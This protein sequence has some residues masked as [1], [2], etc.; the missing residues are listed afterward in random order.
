MPFNKRVLSAATA[1]AVAGSLF[2]AGCDQQQQQGGGMPPMGPVEVGVVTITPQRVDLTSTLSGRVIPVRRAEIRPQVSGLITDVLFTQGAL[3]KP[4]DPLFQIDPAPYK[5]TADAATAAVARAEAGLEIARLNERRYAEL[6]RTSATSRQSYDD[7]VATRKQA[8]AEVASAKASLAAAQVDLGRTLIVSPIAGRIGLASVSQGAL[9]RF[10]Q[11]EALAI[12]HQMDPIYVDVNQS[13]AELLRLKAD[14]AR[15]ALSDVEP[16]SAKVRLI[17]EDGSAYDQEGEMKLAEG[18]V[19][20]STGTVTL[21]SLFPNPKEQLLPGMFVRATVQV[22][23][24]DKGLLVPQRGITRSPTGDGVAMVVN[25]KG[26]VE[27]RKVTADRAVGDAW[28]VTE[29]IAAGDKVIID[30]LQR[31]QPGMPV[32]P[33][34]GATAA[35]ADAPPAQ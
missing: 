17:L 19:S 16:G 32:K 24:D 8:E 15:G 2:L 6:V 12:V 25:A 10:D 26:E 5:A 18:V 21:R 20:T 14:M 28:L 11:Q 35:A 13:S 9:V 31:I 33:V 23:V 27:A 34:E 4:G 29:G 22:G 30:G 1:L 3:V 7:A